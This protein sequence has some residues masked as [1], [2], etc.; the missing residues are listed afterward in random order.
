VPA[1]PGPRRAF[2]DRRSCGCWRL[3]NLLGPLFQ[4]EGRVLG[5]ARYLA[6]P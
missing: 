2:R 6:L 1:A 3:S 5:I 4:K